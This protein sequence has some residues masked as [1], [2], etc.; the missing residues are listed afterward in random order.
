MYRCSG[1]KECL[2]VLS[3]QGNAALARRFVSV[4][5][6]IDNDSDNE[7]DKRSACV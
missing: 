7:S 3:L 2:K 5:R 4:L 6:Q 1:R